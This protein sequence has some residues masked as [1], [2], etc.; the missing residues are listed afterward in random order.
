MD[1]SVLIQLIIVALTL[2][3]NCV[4]AFPNNNFSE[5]VRLRRQAHRLSP[6]QISEIVDRHNA[7]R[8][9]EGAA[10]MDLMSW[11]DEL[12]TLAAKWAAGCV[13]EHGGQP[14][15]GS[16]AKYTRVGQNLYTATENMFSLTTG[17]QIWYDE[18]KD[19]DFDTR[20]CTE[21][22]MCGH[23]TQVV[24][25]NSSEVGC[26]VHDC[27]KLEKSAKMKGKEALYLVCNY[28]PAGNIAD[29]SRK[30]LQPY[31]K[32]AA[33]SK[34]GSGA[35][36]CKDKLCKRECKSAGDECSCAAHCYNC[37]TLDS[38]TCKCTC[39]NGWHGTDCKVPCKDTDE[40]CGAK[41]GSTWPERWCNDYTRS[42]VKEKCPALCKLCTPDPDAT[43]DKCE[44][45]FGPGAH[46]RTTTT[47]TSAQ[48]TFI[49]AQQAMITLPMVLVALAVN[50]NTAL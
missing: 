12:A 10:N 14:L 50:Y 20:E 2:S 25:A 38:S 17:I 45:V 49:V 27:A 24:W 22:K 37:A 36:W 46:G 6:Q 8:A 29:K 11:N 41:T 21:D 3:L 7:L 40:K 39:A 26:A 5:L 15:V 33:C 16:K 35:G 18:K 28:G 13:W 32:G 30:V 44:P 47:T 42:F 43:A 31:I 4:V 48:S 23:Y 1:M 9:K 19:F 34:C